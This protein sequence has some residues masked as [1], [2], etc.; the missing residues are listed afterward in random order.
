M[1]VGSL[2]GDLLAVAPRWPNG[3]YALGS[4]AA[5]AVPPSDRRSRSPKWAVT[6]RNAPRLGYSRRGSRWP[7]WPVTFAEIRRRGTRWLSSQSAVEPQVARLDSGLS[8]PRIEGP[9]QSR[10]SWRIMRSSGHRRCTQWCWPP[11]RLTGTASGP[12]GTTGR[13]ARQSILLGAF[14]AVLKEQLGMVGRCAMGLKNQADG[15]RD[16]AGHSRCGLR[17]AV[18]AGHYRCLPR[19]SAVRGSDAVVGQ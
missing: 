11:V 10:A 1:T 8:C 16:A 15:G 6:C 13:H 2:A 17:A 18:V 5:C 4:A 14:H 7:K 12:C 9:V 19:P 3:V